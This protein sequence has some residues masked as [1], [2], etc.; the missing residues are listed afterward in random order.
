MSGGRV[1]VACSG[2]A[3]HCAQVRLADGSHRGGK[4]YP[5]A[6]A[7][8]N[9]RALP[10]ET[11]AAS[12]RVHAACHPMMSTAPIDRV[13]AEIDAAADEAVAFT[14]DLIRIPTVNPPGEAYEDC[15]RLIGER[16]AALRLRRRVLRRRGPARAHPPPSPHQRRRHAA[17][18]AQTS[19]SCTSTATSTSSP[20]GTAGPCDPFGGEVD[21]GRIYGR[22]S[23]DMKAGIAAALFAVE[24]IRRAGVELAG[25]GRDQR[26]GR[27][28]ERRLRRRRPGW[29]STAASAPRAPTS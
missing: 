11:R 9:A 22:G 18:A 20:P 28:R 23:C 15:A 10:V 8:D 16:L 4:S 5:M 13:V 1:R 27:R 7:F 12:L 6:C 19:P 29:P 17:R 14:S 24:G 2:D 21:D 3:A 26:H 25:L